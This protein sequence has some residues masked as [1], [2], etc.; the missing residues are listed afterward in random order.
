M[1]NEDIQVMDSIPKATLF[2]IAKD[3]AARI[4]GVESSESD[5][6]LQEIT[7]TWRILH[8]NGIVAQKVKLK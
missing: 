8:E 4:A 6:Y 7:N 5:A 3:L 2:M 1:T